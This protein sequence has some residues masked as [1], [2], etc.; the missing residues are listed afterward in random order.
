M[1]GI[2]GIASLDEAPVSMR[3]LRSMNEVLVHRGPDEEGTFD[4]LAVALGIRRLRIIGLANGS[5]PIANEDGSVVVVMN[6]EI[7]NFRDLRS[8]LGAAGHRFSTESDAEV[9]VHLYEEHGADFLKELRGMFALALWDRTRGVLLLARDR[10]G[11]KPLYWAV[12]RG[13]LVFASEIKAL[14]ASGLV[15]KELDESAVGPFL[16]QGF[17]PGER[18]LFRH[19]YKLPAGHL[20]E[21][22]GGHAQVRRYWDVPLEPV[23]DAPVRDAAARVRALLE[24]AVTRR[25]MSEVPL[26]AFLSGGV[27]SSA[28]VGL[29]SRALDAPVET[30]AV[31]FADAEYDELVHA[32]AAAER[33]GTRHHEVV[34]DGCPPD[35]LREINWHQDEPATDPASVPTFCLSRFARERVTVVLT[36]EGGDEIFAGYPHYEL[37][38]RLAAL[39]TWA[40]GVRTMARAA[41]RLEGRLGPVGSPRWWKALWVAGL[42]PDERS[43]GW[44]SAFTDAGLERLLAPRVLQ[45][46]NGGRREPFAA[47]QAR[48]GARDAV[49]Q[50][51]YVDSQL[52]LADHLLMKVDKMTM[53]AALEARCPFLDQELVEY[54]WRLPTA[55]KI[56]P[57]GSKLVLRE[58]LAGLVPDELL[59]RPKHGFDV[60]VRR[61]LLR[62]LSDTVDRLLLADSAP[63]AS[64]L[65]RD[66]VRAAWARIRRSDA[67]LLA[68]QLWMLLNFAVWHELHWPSGA[69]A[70]VPETTSCVAS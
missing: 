33:F 18:T 12:Q 5:Q 30:F 9:A 67:P 56:S 38:R 15:P 43:R 2:A 6:G 3:A 69:H 36:G 4:G 63:L 20:L 7:Y 28:V 40:P 49:A 64:L 41:Q 34:V 14:H 11:K 66:A 10:V 24:E 22:R 68:R 42:A 70:T 26:G 50:L 55:M 23:S 16:A 21:L 13:R 52:S 31:G 57:E 1:C 53:A 47:L 51:M 17:V 29:M 37:C 46:V 61:W 32:R 58:A 48:A 60:P 19:V 39:E 8:R 59:R 54:A 45:Q 65:N 62:D 35:L 44:L 27:D 25:L